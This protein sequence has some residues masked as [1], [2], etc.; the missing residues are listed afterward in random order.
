MCPVN[1][2]KGNS[3]LNCVCT[4]VPPQI[5]VQYSVFREIVFICCSGSQCAGIIHSILLE[6]LL[7]FTST[8]GSNLNGSR[9]GMLETSCLV[10]CTQFSR[11]MCLFYM[12]YKLLLY[13][14]RSLIISLVCSFSWSSIWSPKHLPVYQL[15][16]HPMDPSL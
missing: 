8:G 3:T 13:T 14:Q 1:E 11:C 7:A 10:T 9:L 15:S 6:K 5:H 16:D 12:M 4:Y 2:C